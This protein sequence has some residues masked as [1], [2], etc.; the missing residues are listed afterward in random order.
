MRRYFYVTLLMLLSSVTGAFSQSK[1]ISGGNDHGLIICA[2]GYLYTWGNNMDKTIGGPLLGIDETLPGYNA[3]FVTKPMQVRTGNLTFSQVT[4]GSGAFNLAL[5]C[6][7]LVYGWGDN[8]QGGCGQG[9]SGSNIVQY[10]TPVL[11]GEVQVGY[12][13]DGTT[14]GPYL[15]GV[16]F[17]AA[18]TNSGFAIMDDGRVV[19]WGTGEWNPNKT[20]PKVPHYIKGP[21][22]KDLTNVTHISGGDDNCLIRT[23]DGSLYGIGPWNG[24]SKTTSTVAV[25]VLKDED[26]TPLTD[27]RMSAAGDVCGFAVTGDG[28]VWSWG[29]GGWGGSTGQNK[30]GLTHYNALKVS[31]GEYEKISGEKFLT[32]IKEVIGGRGH[33]AAVSKEGYLIYWGCNDDNGGVVPTDAATAKTYSSGAQGVKPILAKYCDATGKPGE[34]VKNAVSISRG[35]NFDF[36]VND[37]DEFYVWGL[38]DLGQ[39]GAGTQT[40]KYNCLIKLET[41]PCDPQDACP[42]VF[43]ID[44][45][46]C[47]G[48][49]I[50]LDCG[51]VVPKGKEERYYISWKKDGVLLNTT[52]KNS[53][54]A[55]RKA[56]KYNVASFKTTEAGLYE[57]TAEYI[58]GNVPCGV[59]EPVTTTCLVTEME[60]PVDTIITDMNCVADELKPSASDNICF[61][62]KVNDKFYKAKQETSWALFATETSKDTLEVVKTK[63]AGSALKFCVSGD[64]IDKGEVHDNKDLPSKDTTYTVWLEDVS[65]FDTYLFKDQKMTTAGSPQSYGL[66]LNIF[67]ASDLKSFDIAAKSY[68]GTAS[69]SATPAV[70]NVEINENGLY[71]VGSRFWQGKT[72]T[73]TIDDAGPNMLTVLCDVNL[74]ANPARG[75]QYIIGVEFKGNASFYVFDSP[76]T[77]QETALF[78]NPIVDSE[79]FGIYAY[80]ATANSYTSSS[81]AGNTLCYANVRFGKLTDYNCGRIQLTARYG[82]PP[83]KRPDG[84]VTIEVDGAKRTADT[85]SFCEESPSVEF[86]VS[87]IEATEGVFDELWFVDKVGADASALQITKNAT[88]ST[89]KT[90]IGWEEAKAGKTEKYYVKVRDNEKPEASA[91]FVYDS[92][93]VRY[94]E[95][96][97]APAIDPIEFCENEED[98]SALTTAL[99]GSAFAPYTVNWYADEAKSKAGAEPDITTLKAQEEAYEFFYSVTDNA[100]GCESAVTSVKVTVNEVPAKPATQVVPLLKENGKSASIAAGATAA[101]SNTL[102]WYKTQDLSSPSTSAPL[103]DLSEAGTFYYWVNQK[104]PAGCVS[105]TATVTVIVNDAPIPAVRDTML[106]VG[107]SIADLSEMATPLNSDYQLKWYSSASAEKGTGDDQAP[108]FTATKAGETLF[109]VSQLNTKTNAESEKSTIHVKVYDVKEPSVDNATP[110]YCIGATADVLSANEVTDGDYFLSSGLEWFDEE[111]TAGATGHK[112]AFTPSTSKAGTKDYWVRQYYTLTTKDK[113]TCYGEPVKIT[114]TVN[115]TEKPASKSN[116]IFNYLKTDVSGG[117]FVDLLTKDKDGVIPSDD[118]ELIWYSDADGKNEISGTPAPTYDEHQEGTDRQEIFYVAQINKTTGCR[119]EL[120]KVVVNISDTPAPTAP[121]LTYC[122]NSDRVAALTATINTLVK[123]ADEY[124]LVWFSEAPNA[125][126]VKEATNGSATAPVPDVTVPAGELEVERIYYVAQKDKSTGAVSVATP[127]TVTV[128]AKPIL[129]TD[130]ASGYCYPQ[131]VLLNNYYEYSTAV[132]KG[133]SATYYDDA[134]QALGGPEVAESGLYH[135]TGQFTVPESDELCISSKEDIQVTIDK[136]SDVKITAS[137][138]TCPNTSITLEASSDQNTSTVSYEWTS[139]NGDNGTGASYKSKEMPG[140]AGDKYTFTLNVT[141]GACTASETHEVTIGDGRIEGSI[142]ISEDNNTEWNNVDLLATDLAS[143]TIYTCGGDLSLKPSMTKTEGSYYWT[144]NGSS[145]GSDNIT[146]TESGTY[147]VS[148]VNE[149]PTSVEVTVVAVPLT[150]TATIS[151]PEI[152]EEAS[153]TITLS[154]TCPEEPTSIVWTK[155][156][157]PYSPANPKSIA[158]SPA[159]YS[160]NGEYAFTITN[161][162]C[163]VTNST[164]PLELKVKQNIKV[165]DATEPYIV[166]RGKSVEMEVNVE[167]PNPKD[168]TLSTISWKDQSGAEV[169]NGQQ[170]SLDKVESDKTYEITLADDNYC[171]TTTTI[172][173]WVDAKLEMTTSFADTLCFGEKKEFVIDTTGTGSFRKSPKGTLSVVETIDGVVKDITDLFSLNAD[174]MLVALLSPAKNASYYV[175]FDYDGQHRDTTDKIEVLQPIEID[176]PAVQTVCEGE[177]VTI[178]LPKVS[179]E[180]TTIAWEEDATITSGLTDKSITVVAAYNSTTAYNHR[181]SYNYN[182]VASYAGCQNITMMATLSVDEPITGEVTGDTPICEGSTTTL[183]ASSFDAAEYIWTADD[184]STYLAMGATITERLDTTRLFHLSMTRGTCTKDTTFGVKVTSIPVIV[185]VDSVGLRDRKVEMDPMKGTAPFEFA[186]DSEDAFFPGDVAQ[187]LSFTS[188]IVYVVDAVGCKNSFKFSLVAPDVFPK[189]VHTPE[190]DGVNDTWEVTNL[191]EVYPDAVVRIFDRYGKKLA[192]YKGE[193]PGWDGYYN[194]KPMPTTDYWYE[195]EIEEIEKTYVGHFTLLRR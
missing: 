71:V 38:N 163:S 95:K 60:M 192:E 57:V 133:F 69:V 80:G 121:S 34:V 185:N 31:S 68:S 175:S 160:D 129:K 48:E 184:D 132:E 154:Y 51:F 52:T 153:S 123:S 187:D 124:E 7:K 8:S 94:Y 88:S 70:Y 172:N 14:G 162:G 12:N 193:D 180:G 136:L 104:S 178:T 114:V 174:G 147:K 21:D 117:K 111:I 19:G 79:G 55:E 96:P 84:T 77:A 76:K 72:Q 49:E 161:R 149:C 151:D 181:S 24:N 127:I 176:L 86:S 102:Y 92:I 112:N 191:R 155:D 44:R 43:M 50:E 166:V 85:L 165:V 91:C 98:K 168:V 140:S 139:T 3:D 157:A 64:K 145:I 25:P 146:V 101:G 190:G 156:G 122:Q 56:D 113:S 32:D 135:V 2:E 6:H 87:G 105:D 120:Q 5:S 131:K 173:L 148:Y 134:D 90:K 93:V 78:S 189:K 116:Y 33:G 39:C 63:G 142:L 100:T 194:G 28:Y 158:F 115:E 182:F 40:A 159:Q 107:M 75:T 18:S 46:K 42:Q 62:A 137:D 179:P 109:Y 110:E 89:L 108:S 82:C 29:N 23:E 11:K 20:D 106:C 170:Y 35:D 81:N 67:S 1:T 167:V 73:F 4:S 177:E 169:N 128:Y 10:P 97:K 83:C 41:I 65:S 125:N 186:L 188:H 36:M 126:P 37:K 130:N 171:G 54:A 13:E 119:S 152:C 15:G 59:C 150:A 164:E 118:C 9:A 66:M 16:T 195:I 74:P 99:A 58:G 103:Q 143:T 30:N 183:D 144:K 17:I 22:G 47:P 27:I 45:R 53:T 61:E 26:G 138:R 141:A